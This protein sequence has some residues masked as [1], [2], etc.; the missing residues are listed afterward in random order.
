M[1]L[2]TCKLVQGVRYINDDTTQLCF[3][4]LHNN[5]VYFLCI[6]VLFIFVG[7]IPVTVFFKLFRNR[8]FLKT[9]RH[10]VNLGYF[11]IGYSE[12]NTLSVYWELV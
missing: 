7:I 2:M 12:G 11:L 10:K 3:T 8:K 5:Y 9:I 6:P 1:G 4:N